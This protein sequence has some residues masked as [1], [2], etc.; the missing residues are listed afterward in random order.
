MAS[1][2]TA[3]S[4]FAAVAV[5]PVVEPPVAQ[6]EG[7]LKT[8]QNRLVKNITLGFWVPI[9]GNSDSKQYFEAKLMW[10]FARE[11]RQTIYQM[12]LH[13]S[14]NLVLTSP[15]RYFVRYIRWQEQHIS[16]SV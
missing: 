15:F 1:V 9:L 8:K 6:H 7:A 2:V 3:A 13:T 5:P 14:N 12:K 16:A 11:P 4:A 10:L